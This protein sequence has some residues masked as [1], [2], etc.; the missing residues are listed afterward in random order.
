MSVGSDRYK[1]DCTRTGFYGENCPTPKLLTRIKLLRKYTANMV[2]SMLAYFKGIWNTVN[3]I[4]F[5]RN[6]VM[7]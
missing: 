4:P 2:Y 3:N 5:L 6:S 7:R 1:C